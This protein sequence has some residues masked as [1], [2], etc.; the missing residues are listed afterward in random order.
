VQPLDEDNVG[1]RQVAPT[2]KAMIARDGAGVHVAFN[3]MPNLTYQVEAADAAGTGAWDVIDT[4]LADAPAEEA[5]DAS[6]LPG[7]LYR[8]RLLIDP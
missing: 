2:V 8:V 7:R 6:P 1:L 4:I 5:L 3:A